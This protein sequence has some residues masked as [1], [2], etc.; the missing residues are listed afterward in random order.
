MKK[1]YFFILILILTQFTFAQ[2]AND[3]C[4]S[5]ALI[6][7]TNTA[8]NFTFDINT[9]LVNNQTICSSTED[10][11]DV[12]YEF[13]MPYD[14]NIHVDG[15][16]FWNGF[17]LYDSCGGAEIDCGSS[18]TLFT[19]LLSGNT[20]FLRI[21][22]TAATASNTTYQNFSIKA[23]PTA[24]NDDCT[25]ST[26]IAISTASTTVNFEIG[27][28]SINNEI[29]CNGTTAFDYVDIWYDFNMPVNGNVYIDAGINWNNIALYD[30]CAGTE[31][32]CGSS[33]ELITGLTAGTN[34]KL[35]IFRTTP[36][37]NKTYLSF[38]ITAYEEATNEDCISSENITV[39]TTIATINFDIAGASINNEIGCSG[40]TTQDY[41]DIWYDFTMPV[42]G[43]LFINGAINWNNF[44]LY[45]ACGGTEI[46]CGAAN[47][48]IENLT[49]GTN[50]KLRVFRTLARTPE[51]G[52]RS[53]T[54]Q[55][56]EN[57]TN[58]NCV[59]SENINVST[60]EATINFDIAG[61]S[62][63]N[64]VG[65]SGT[66]PSDYTDIWY[67]FTMPVNGNLFVN[68]AIN[69]NNFALYDACGGTEIQCGA[70][71]E[72]IENLTSG[73]N[74][75][76]R[77]FRTLPRTTENGYRSFTIQAFEIINNDDCTSAEN[78]TVT[79]TPTTVNFGIAGASINNEVGCSGTTAEDYA[80]IWYDFTMPIDGY[81]VIDGSL[82][83]NNFSLYDACSGN[84][85]G[86]FSSQGNIAGLT[87]GTTYKLRVFRTLALANNDGYKS[88]TIHSTETLST[89]NTALEDNIHVYPN[90]ADA[91]LNI[92][93]SKNQTISSI[94]LFNILGKKVLTTKAETMDISSYP[95]GIYLLKIATEKGE[96]TKKIV[97][98]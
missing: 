18:S 37:V 68:G 23:F 96:V 5:A 44:A 88:F 20:Y 28:A 34:Y 53:F 80:D 95:S 51:N 85:L 11:A 36:N 24:T 56:F 3:D 31:I 87:S 58:D 67:D 55:A 7:V 62:I 21:Y 59:S 27:G 75:K 22:R 45:D 89:N 48:L 93:S 50:Y 60:T 9:A 35:R 32:Q 65:C 52:Y 12:W 43:N 38:N 66:T 98:Q 76:L 25:S 79:N 47:E 26:N 86:C 71:N 63:N 94:S 19:N 61:A 77:V 40:T 97:I 29:G 42:N 90:P 33:N 14:G 83:W 13:S 17:A 2:P 41:T 72:L 84:E 74:Y 81:I 15:S 1:R 39:S 10:F 70:T 8:T 54:I 16:L 69:W 46:Q 57:A 64:E 82:S 91:I 30:T 49:S 4:S 92:A 6:T 78:I 73:T